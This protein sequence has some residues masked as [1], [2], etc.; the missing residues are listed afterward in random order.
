MPASFPEMWLNRVISNLVNND[1][2]PWLDGIA[3]LDVSIVEI[4]SGDASEMNQIH[5]PTSI[6]SPTV[7][8]NNTTYPIALQAYDDAEVTV[9]LDKY[10]TLATT[11]SDDQIIGAS[12]RQIDFVT[13]SHTRTINQKKYLK[14]IHALAP[15]TNAADKPVLL[16]TGDAVTTGSNK[17]LRCRYEDLVALAA[18]ADALGW[19]TDGRRLVLSDDHKNDLLLDRKNFGDQLVNYKTGQP[20]PVI[21][22]WNI[23]MN[24]GNPYYNSV[25]KLAFGSAPSATNFRASVAFMPE[26]VAKK[27]GLT[28]QYFADAKTDPQ[29]QTNRLNYRHYFIVLPMLDM[30]RAALAS[31]LSA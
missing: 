7:L 3:E 19:P 15:N 20:A 30:Y 1:V 14:A 5:I 21:A 31:G 11:L 8:I 23:Y 25:T 10:Q 17:R 13:R 28:K 24:V 26:N 9:N 16:T 22:G 6:F 4:G 2:A 12:Y 27:T 18:Q 29:N